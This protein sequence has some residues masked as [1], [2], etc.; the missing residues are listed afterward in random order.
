MHH[1]MHREELCAVF[2]ETKH[3]PEYESEKT[4]KEHYDIVL[5]DHS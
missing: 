2:D 3:L 5:A 4:S 1:F